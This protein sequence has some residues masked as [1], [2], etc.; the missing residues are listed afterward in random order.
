M[1]TTL[2]TMILLSLVACFAVSARAQTAK[3]GDGLKG[4]YAYDLFETPVRCASCHKDFA[5]QYEQAMMSQAYTHAWDEIE[6]FKLAVPHSQRDP[7]FKDAQEGCNGCH[8]PLAFM[9]GEVPPPK[10]FTGS[11]AD[12]SVSCDVCHTITGT[13]EQPP[14]N[15]SF[16]IEPG[17]TKLGNREGIES[18]HHLTKKHDFTVSPDLCG[19]CHNEKNP[20]GLWVKSTQLEWKE[21]PYAKEGVRCQDCHMPPAKGRNSIMSKDHDDIAQHLFT[22]AHSPARLAGAV[23][24]NV[25]PDVRAVVPGE[26]LK[27]TVSCYN[28]KAGHKI[29]SGSVEERQLWLTVTAIDAHGKTYHLPVDAKGFDGEEFTISSN[30]LAFQ[31]MGFMMDTPDFK[32]LPRDALPHEGDRVF[33]MAY[34]D[35]QDRM[36]IAQWNTAR[37]GTDYR[38]GPRETKTETYTWKL[39][40]DLP[41]GR[42]RI[43]AEMQYRRLIKSVGDYLGVPAEEMKAEFINRGESWFEAVDY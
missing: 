16:T 9:A 31:D 38:I 33:R 21:G 35:P 29:P 10:P 22:G 28:H 6:Y 17:R 39:P 11:R 18:P 32:G 26:Q 30:A 12:E 25:Y 37:F 42:V 1:G 41:L 8:A 20:F 27:I 3:F 13:G 43:V 24:V 15:F 19:S 2:R 14:V 36:T 4:G 5:R 40:A 34:F 23:E 7:K